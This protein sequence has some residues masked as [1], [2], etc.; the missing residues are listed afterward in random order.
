MAMPLPASHTKHLD[1]LSHP[2]PQDSSVILPLKQISSSGSTSTG[3]TGTTLWLSGQVLSSYLS[4]LPSSMSEKTLRVI[5]LGAGI[6]YTSLVLASLGYQVTSTDIEPVFS[7]VLAP[8]LE[9]G[10]DQLVRSRLPCNVYARKLDW[11]D[12]SRLWQ[13][14]RS[15]KDLEWVAEGWDMVVMTDTFYAPQI[16][17]PLWNTLIYLSSNSKSSPSLPKEGKGKE[18]RPPIYIALEARDPVFISRALDIG[19]QKGFEL[20]KIAVR[21]VARDVERWGWSR[22]DWEGIEVWKGRWNG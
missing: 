1:L 3:A 16:L 4:S 17:E 12:I 10:K 6:G 14:E 22:E 13:G 2:L 7:S 18:R 5:E 15:E 9:T 11:M 20:K 21:R 8:N 19:R